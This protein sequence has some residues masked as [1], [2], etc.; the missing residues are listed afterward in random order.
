[1][2]MWIYNLPLHSAMFM[3]SDID[4][5]CCLCC[6]NRGPIMAIPKSYCTCWFSCKNKFSFVIEAW[7]KHMH[8]ALMLIVPI[9]WCMR[10]YWEFL[11]S[12][13]IMFIAYYYNFLLLYSFV[14]LS[15]KIKGRLSVICHSLYSEYFAHYGVINFIHLMRFQ[16]RD[17]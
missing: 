10:Q 16:C 15:H 2:S 17:P 3:Q 7:Q 9:A 6:L 13:F 8:N 4:L 14:F 1:M 11:C 5:F 12:F